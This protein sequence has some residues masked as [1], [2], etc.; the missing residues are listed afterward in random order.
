MLS[1]PDSPPMPQ[2]GN[3]TTS[4]LLKPL[5]TALVLLCLTGNAAAQGEQ[6]RIEVGAGLAGML[7]ENDESASGLRVSPGVT[8]QVDINLARRLAIEVRSTWF[9][10]EESIRFQSQGCRRS[11]SW[12]GRRRRSWKA[13][14][15][16]SMASFCL[17]S[18]TSRIAR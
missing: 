15:S 17:A 2:R 18:F 11:T 13:V 6:T 5:T 7:V 16:R 3:L 4:R 9:P 1:S 14:A 12:Q 8:G 10:R